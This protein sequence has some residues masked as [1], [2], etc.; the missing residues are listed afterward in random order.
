M[1]VLVVGTDVSVLTKL[2]VGPDQAEGLEERI[3]LCAKLGAVVTDKRD[4][5]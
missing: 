1:S 3:Q 2:V 4:K 5:G